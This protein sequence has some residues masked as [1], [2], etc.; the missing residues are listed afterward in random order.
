MHNSI[1]LDFF[2]FDLVFFIKKKNWIILIGN[3]TDSFESVFGLKFQNRNRNGYRTD[4]QW[5]F[6]IIYVHTYCCHDL[7]KVADPLP[8]NQGIEPLTLTLNCCHHQLNRCLCLCLLLGLRTAAAG[9]CQL[10]R[11]P[12]PSAALCLWIMI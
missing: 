2:G 1:R 7:P 8:K 10:S 6:H 12:A 4:I 9:H 3:R 11:D 5:H